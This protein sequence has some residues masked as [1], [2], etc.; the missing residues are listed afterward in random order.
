MKTTKK[1]MV[2]AGMA[3]VIGLAVSGIGLA[4]ASVNGASGVNPMSG[5]VAA[6]AQK[7]NLNSSDVQQVFNEQGAQMRT[8]MQAKQQQAF[9]DRI[10]KAVSDGK[11]TQDQ[12]NKILAEKTLI[13]SQI[14]ALADKTN[15]ERQ[16]AMKTIMDSLKQWSTDNNIPTGYLPFGFGGFEGFGHGHGRG[17]DRPGLAPDSTSNK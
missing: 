15:T 12:A 3:L 1:T 11:L 14:A 13:E 2:F 5:L 6:I 9:I 10:N 8:Q 7:F 17:L 16:T 4:K